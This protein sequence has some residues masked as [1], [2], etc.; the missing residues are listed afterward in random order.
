MIASRCVKPERRRRAIINAV[1]TKPETE[2][3]IA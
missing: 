2:G 3:K 1:G